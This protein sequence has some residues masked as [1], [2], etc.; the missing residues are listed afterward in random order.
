MKEWLRAASKAVCLEK[1]Q[2]VIVALL[3]NAVQLAERTGEWGR[4]GPGLGSAGFSSH[5]HSL[6]VSPG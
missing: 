5:H 1:L 4:L 6:W 2:H 3:C